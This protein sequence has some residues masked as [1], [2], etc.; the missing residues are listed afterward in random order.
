MLIFV[1]CPF[2]WFSFAFDPLDDAVNPASIGILVGKPGDCEAPI[3]C[4][5]DAGSDVVCT[6]IEVIA[7]LHVNDYLCDIS[8]LS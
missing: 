3:V 2:Y 7:I 1:G 4:I 5:R 8:V 6:G